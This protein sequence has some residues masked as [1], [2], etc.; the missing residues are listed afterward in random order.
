MAENAAGQPTLKARR[1]KAAA[2]PIEDVGKR[3]RAMMP[4][5]KEGR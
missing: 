4:W 1:E 2:D 5:L 3:M